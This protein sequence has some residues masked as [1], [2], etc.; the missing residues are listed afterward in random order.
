MTYML[1]PLLSLTKS[2]TFLSLSQ[3]LKG[4][5]IDSILREPINELAALTKEVLT[6]QEEKFEN[7]DAP[8]KFEMVRSQFRTDVAELDRQVREVGLGIGLTLK[9]QV[10]EV[11]QI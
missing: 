1:K 10:R 11:I 8:E 5:L 7:L 2:Q 6:E 4:K 3:A 9:C